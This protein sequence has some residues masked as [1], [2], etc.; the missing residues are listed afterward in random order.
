MSQSGVL[1]VITSGGGAT[2]ETLT[3]NSGGPVGPD[4][5]FNINVLGNNTTGINIVG[6]PVSNTLSVV[7]IQ[8]TTSQ[9][10]TVTLASDAQAIAGTDNVNALTSSNLAAKLG[11]Q[12]AHSLAVFKGTSSALTALGVATNGQIPIGSTGADP[13]LGNITSTGGTIT[14]TNGAGTIN[15]DVTAGTHVLETLTGNSGG[16]IS[17][18]AGNINVIGTNTTTIVGNPATNTLTITPTSSGYPITPYV[19]GPVGQAGYQTIQSAVN[20]ANAAGGGQVW[21][22]EGTYTENL[23]LFSGIQLS[24]P[25]E[26]SVTIIGTHTPPSSGTLNIFRLTLQSATNIFSSNAAGTAAIIMED[27]S[28]AVTN[29]YTFNLPNWTA[30]GSVAVQD[31]GPFGTNDGFINNT[32]GCQFFAFSCGIGNGTANPMILSGTVGMGPG[33][34]VGC[35]IHL[36]TGANFSSTSNEYSQTITCSN[37]STGSFEGDIFS[38]GTTVPITQSSSGSFI[39]AN[40]LINTS[41]NPAI[42][43]AGAGVLSL[44]NITFTGNDIIANTLTLSTTGGLYPPG[45]L[46]TAGFIW[47]S[48]GPGVCPTFQA[49]SATGAITTITGNTGGAESSSAGNFNIIGTGSITVAG[50]ANTETVQLTGLTNHSLLVGAGTATITNLGVATNGQLPIGS[51][52]A[53]PVLATLTAGGGISITNG[54]GSITIASSTTAFAYTNV[55]HAA[56]PYT[57]LTTDYYISVDCSG[58]TVQLNFPNAPTA[59]QTWI[60]KDRTGSASTN[61]ISITT[62]GGTVTF[63]GITTYKIVSNFGAVNLIAN[64]TPTYEVY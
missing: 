53:D 39:L 54:A 6:M 64:S 46:G 9:R 18:I 34:Q 36:V 10:G 15:L 19:V 17:P 3:G 5:A 24:S 56:S 50:S 35:P 28:V 14:V 57:V 32:G 31:I 58:G 59:K 43:G 33:A 44:D 27:C 13:V 49:V 30:S 47:T 26:Q 2:V 21:I 23:T 38:T 12:T 42:A 61:N 37:N 40:V 20:A 41:H 48:N 62:P 8:A 7:G 25:S 52:G 60:V 63:D 55:N 51:T 11:T 16:A 1:T 22:Q 45:N 4:G 29:G